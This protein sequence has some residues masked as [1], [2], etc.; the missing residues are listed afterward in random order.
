MVSI[1][2][3]HAAAPFSSDRRFRISRLP[4][5][6]IARDTRYF[7]KVSVRFIRE[8]D[9]PFQDQPAESGFSSAKRLDLRRVAH[10]QANR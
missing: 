7:T 1:H 2:N 8:A 4:S 6:L 5:I 9:H 10:R 3:V